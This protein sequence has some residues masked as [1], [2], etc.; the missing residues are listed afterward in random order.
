MVLRPGV[1]NSSGA[2]SPSGSAAAGGVGHDGGLLEIRG[3]AAAL[4][5]GDEI[6]AGVGGHHELVRLAAAHGAGV[7]FHHGVLQAAAIEDAAVGLVVLLV[8]GVEPGWSMSKE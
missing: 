6:L 4:A 7:R 3:V 5:D 8:G 1:W 2:R